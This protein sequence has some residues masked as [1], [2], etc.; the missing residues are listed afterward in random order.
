MT[1]HNIVKELKEKVLAGGS[2]TREEASRL[3]AWPVREEVWDAAEEI[4]R[5]MCPRS[6][7]S[8]SIV[9]ARSGRCPENCKWCA[10]SAHFSTGCNTYDIIDDEECMTEARHNHSKGVKRFSLVASG[11]AV[12]GE[13]LRHICYLLKRVKDEVG[14][15]T[16]ASLGLIG[17][18]E[19]I[20]L[21]DAG[22]RRYHCNLETAPSHFATLCST[23]TID[24]KLA[25]IRMAHELGF[26][27]CSGG[28]IGMGETPE[29][30]VEFAFT[31]READPVSI[32]VNI[33]CPIPGTP[34]EAAAPLT[35]TEILD[36]VAMM[37]FVHPKVQIRFAGGRSKMS[38]ETQLRAMRIAVNGGIVGDLLT[39]VGSQIDDD[40][41]LTNE[42]GYEF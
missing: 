37:R 10:Q 5:A 18:E 13:A 15:S 11:R 39:T 40:R 27:V 33:L 14:I 38:R 35:E 20:A 17:R 32:P 6:F 3:A 8:C 25:T 16:C 4:T 1:D 42:A 41:K 29:Q 36:T 21:R 7:D 24:D 9:N 12:K 26:E 28:I 31:L 23:H 34:L 19:L 2:I 30:R 22:V